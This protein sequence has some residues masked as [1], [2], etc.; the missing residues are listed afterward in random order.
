VTI[1]YAGVCVG[2]GNAPR[3]QT[4]RGGDQSP[5]T[6]ICPACSGRFELRHDRLPEH[7]TANETERETLRATPDA[8]ASASPDASKAQRSGQSGDL[9]TGT[10]R[11]SLPRELQSQDDG[12]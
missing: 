12:S 1:P 8:S 4:L 5:V 6:G 7:E 2:S 11:D 3:E 10:Q 9:R